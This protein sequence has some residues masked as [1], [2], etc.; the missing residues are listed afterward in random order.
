MRA[1][2]AIAAVLLAIAGPAHA[3]EL[4]VDVSGLQP[5]GKGRLAVWVYASSEQWDAGAR[6]PLAQGEVVA[7]R[8]QARF[9]FRDLAPGDYA[10]MVLHDLDG[11]GRFDRNSL[12]IPRDGYGFSNNPL[13]V[14]R[15]GFA[16]VRFIVPASG[17]AVSVRMR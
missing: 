14:G 8:R 2:A 11:N 17:A 1:A 10:V 16:R 7:G 9:V 4:T 6:P 3:A 13:A 12:G 15:P 5:T